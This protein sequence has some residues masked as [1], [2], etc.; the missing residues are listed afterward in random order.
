MRWCW[1]NAEQRILARD[2]SLKAD[3]VA[4]SRAI[5]DKD[6]DELFVVCEYFRRLGLYDEILQ[7][8]KFKHLKS[9]G[10]ERRKLWIARTLNLRG[11]HAIALAIAK[12]ANPVDFHD[13]RHLGSIYLTNGMFREAFECFF[14]AQKSHPNKSSHGFR[15]LTISLA[16]THGLLGEYEKAISLSSS[17]VEESPDPLT[18]AIALSA[19][20]EYWSLSGRFIEGKND[21][22]LALKIC[23]DHASATDMAY[24]KKWL[25]WTEGKLGNLEIAK[26]HLDD[27]FKRQ[28]HVDRKAESWVSILFLA[29]DLGLVSQET[30][31][32]IYFY[33]GLIRSVCNINGSFQG[34][35]L[36]DHVDAKIHL[37]PS[38][39]EIKIDG[40]YRYGF[41]REMEA[42][43][44]LALSSK[45]GISR[46]RL[47]AQLW[48]DEV[49]SRIELD[50][51]LSVL[52]NS[53]KEKYRISVVNELGFLKLSDDCEKDICVKIEESSLPSLVQAKQ[54]IS[55]KDI[56]AHYQMS[57][58]SSHALLQDWIEQG[59][60]SGGQKRGE[61]L[62]RIS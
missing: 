23:P 1:K 4:Y 58:G 32:S 55:L 10:S 40:F 21:L 37:F 5:P 36:N 22:E 59:L 9:F 56:Q 16:D 2:P 52:I 15:M 49:F 18:K 57:R 44:Q 20:G 53:L 24:I 34:L 31:N 38:S 26:R 42:M 62:R 39:Q 61:Y 8:L 48:P 43:L 12:N 51:R 19:R 25:G 41:N 29:A 33:P 50:N 6:E 11:N 27:A 7:V 54:N 28:Y 47:M 46:E 3:L 13:Y 60:V 17:V 35:S 45:Y 14:V 30:A